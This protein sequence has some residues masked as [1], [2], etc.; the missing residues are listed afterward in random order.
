MF[1][2]ASGD[3]VSLSLFFISFSLGRLIIK[4]LYSLFVLS[5]LETEKKGKLKTSLSL[6]ILLFYSHG[7]GV[8]NN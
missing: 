4:L 3:L 1:V 5:L 6:V 2:E 7:M 8:V